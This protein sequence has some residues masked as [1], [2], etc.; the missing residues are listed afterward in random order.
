MKTGLVI[1]VAVDVI[2]SIIGVLVL[3]SR[4][5]ESYKGL[6]AWM[7]FVLCVF[8]G[9]A[10]FT[11]YG[12]LL[13]LMYAEAGTLDRSAFL[14]Q[15]PSGIV[16]AMIYAA[17]LTTS[18]SSSAVAL[19]YGE[20][21]GPSPESFDE[22]RRLV[23][24]GKIDAAIRE[25]RRIAEEYPTSPEPLLAA[26]GVME[27]GRR[28]REAAALLRQVMRGFEKDD[29]AWS[30]AAA[31]LAP[32]MKDHLGMPEEAKTL[33]RT[34]T[35]RNR[36]SARP[37]VRRRARPPLDME[38]ASR[39]NRDPLEQNRAGSE[40][41]A[42]RRRFREDPKNPRPLFAAALALERE[43]RPLEAAGALRDVVRHFH[44]NDEIWSDAAYRLAQL[45]EQKLDD[46]AAARTLLSQITGRCP[47]TKA[48]EIAA[49]RQRDLGMR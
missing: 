1:L 24:E 28:Y 9:I 49:E 38:G 20:S 32:L 44:E 30:R 43:G 25:Y 21:P 10:H 45:L 36:R 11:A 19:L 34:V 14:L 22:A 33:A 3:R 18:F 8:A 5:I 27:A 13:G 31:R 42:C 37:D 2:L 48:G 16:P 6:P 46:A 17:I 15:I 7:S 26:A 35:D 40:V 47:H 41:E 29:D 23:C 4:R 12:V 39:G